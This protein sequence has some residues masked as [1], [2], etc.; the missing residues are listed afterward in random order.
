M[1]QYLA[2]NS[3]PIW[4]GGAVAFTMALVVYLQTRGNTALLSM[5]A[6]VAIAATLLVTERMIE[7]PAEAVERTLY[8]LA[9]TVEA[10][11]VHGA[12]RF[13][14]PSATGRIRKDIETLMP[15]LKIERA[16][17]LGTPHIQIDAGADSQAATVECRGLVI[18]TDKRN[19]MKGGAEDELLIKWVRQGDRWLINSY[20]TKKNWDRALGR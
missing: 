12:L 4:M 9:A 11:D 8:E 7:T 17:V 2:E 16:R 14:A 10:N 5:G 6:V 1:I 15:L 18:A 20:G 3:L 13:L 19:G